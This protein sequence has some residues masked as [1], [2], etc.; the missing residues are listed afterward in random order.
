MP[1]TRE[2]SLTKTI[3]PWALSLGLPIEEALLLDRCVKDDATGCWIWLG[4]IKSNGY[5]RLTVNRKQHHAH[6]YSLKIF[7]GISPPSNMDVCHKCDNRACINPEHLFVGTRKENMQDA[8]T[9]GRIARGEKL[10]QAR[11]KNGVSE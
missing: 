6:R 4:T 1:I 3:S 7:R 2:Q 9:K 8:L 11:G 10:I 5:G